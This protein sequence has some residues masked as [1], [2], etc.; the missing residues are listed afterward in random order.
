W[1]F[2]LDH[3]WRSPQPLPNGEDSPHLH[4]LRIHLETGRAFST[5]R[6]EKLKVFTGIENLLDQ[7]QEI[8]FQNPDNPFAGNFDGSSV[9]GNA[10]GRRWYAGIR[11][12][13]Y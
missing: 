2:R 11:L 3:L 4:D 13:L 9:W 6:N 1:N 5:N 12:Q 10:L 7:R 8:L